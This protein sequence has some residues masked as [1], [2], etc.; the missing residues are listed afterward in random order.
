MIRSHLVLADAADVRVGGDVGGHAAGDHEGLAG[1]DLA[2]RAPSPVG[3]G[4]RAGRSCRRGRRSRSSGGRPAGRGRRRRG[5]RAGWRR[6]GRGWRPRSTGGSACRARTSPTSRRRAATGRGRRSAP[7][8]PR[9]RSRPARGRGWRARRPG[10]S[11]RARGRWSASTRAGPHPGDLLVPALYLPRICR[12]APRAT[13]QKRGGSARDVHR[14]L[15][16]GH[17]V[18][19]HL[20][21]DLH[22]LLDQRL[23]DLGLG[24][25]LDDLALDED[26]AL[27]VAGGDAEVGLAG[28]AGAVDDLAH[29]GDAQRT[30]MPSRPAVTS[31][32]SL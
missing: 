21:G 24:D 20:L 8:R 19:L 25:G 11:V 5:R 6:W 29:D 32:A 28:L 30:S 10:R 1:A 15:A 18:G 17:S 13:R 2:G 14:G 4:A 26:L 16:G 9:R 12:A 27:A 31:S 7:G 3:A 23:H 22:G